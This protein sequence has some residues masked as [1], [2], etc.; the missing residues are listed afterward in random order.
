MGGDDMQD[1]IKSLEE[2]FKQLPPENQREV[3]SYIEFLIARQEARARRQPQFDW[4]G[5]LADLRDQYSSVDLQ[6]QITDWRS[7]LE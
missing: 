6:H 4:A 7:E 5:A 1:Q 2:L 3:R